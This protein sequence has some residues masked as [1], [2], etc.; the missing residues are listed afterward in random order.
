MIDNS[1]DIECDGRMIKSD[2]DPPGQKSVYI[3]PGKR[4]NRSMFVLLSVIKIK[5]CEN[6]FINLNR[7]HCKRDL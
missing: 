1:I 7:R 6:F 5:L 2:K 4:N 3:I